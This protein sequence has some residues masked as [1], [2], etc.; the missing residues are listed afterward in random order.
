MHPELEMSAFVIRQV[1]G[2]LPRS[3]AV[4]GIAESLVKSKKYLL[5]MVVLSP[6]LTAVLV[7]A[8]LAEGR[9]KLPK[10]ATV[11]NVDDIETGIGPGNRTPVEPAKLDSDPSRR[12]PSAAPLPTPPAT[13]PSSP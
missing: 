1:P 11:F 4:D 3:H 8:Y 2:S 5:P 13:S 9:M 6:H 10:N 12:V 7:V